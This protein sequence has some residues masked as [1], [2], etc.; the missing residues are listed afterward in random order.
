MGVTPQGKGITINFDCQFEVDLMRQRAFL[1]TGCLCRAFATVVD[2]FF[3][4]SANW[5]W[6]TR[7][8]SQE[9][10]FYMRRLRQ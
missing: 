6:R 7:D 2:G 8:G 1:D 10:A 5:L 4:E 9:K 3:S